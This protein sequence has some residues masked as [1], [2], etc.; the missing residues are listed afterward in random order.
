MW[1][2]LNKRGRGKV[3][4]VDFTKKEGRGADKPSVVNADGQAKLLAGRINWRKVA[5]AVE[6]RH[7]KEASD[8]GNVS[9][10]WM[11]SR[12]SGAFQT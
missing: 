11:K 9:L 1:G 7:R 6:Y 4:R 5:L 3:V 2:R 8:S 10:K 12:G